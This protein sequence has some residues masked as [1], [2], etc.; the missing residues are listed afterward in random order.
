M[1]QER[2]K[3]FTGNPSPIEIIL[4]QSLEQTGDNI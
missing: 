3:Q 4:D 2:I 1:V